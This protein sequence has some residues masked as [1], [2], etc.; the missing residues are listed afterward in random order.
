MLVMRPIT[1]KY[2]P[3]LNQLI[4]VR[5]ENQ[6]KRRQAI[7]GEGSA[8]IDLVRLEPDPE[9][10]PVGMWD[11]NNL[12]AAFVL[13]CAQ[14]GTGWSEWGRGGPSLLVSHAHTHPEERARFKIIT[15]WLRDYAARAVDGPTWPRCTV[16]DLKLAEYLEQ[17]CGWRCVGSVVRGWERPRYLLEAVPECI[18]IGA[19]I[20]SEGEL[21]AVTVREGA[22]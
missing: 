7:G 22:P 13:Q 8:L 1:S 10:R 18:E 5:Q 3:D 9:L 14:P 12:V 2:L 16:R 6:L 15:P 4:W 17:Q 19:L 20:R 21:A 11:D